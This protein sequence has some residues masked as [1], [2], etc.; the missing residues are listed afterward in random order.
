MCVKPFLI[1]LCFALLLTS[2]STELK[3]ANAFVDQSRQTQLAVYFPE[4]AQVTLVQDSDGT[5][6]KVLDSVNQNA[7]LDIMYYAFAEE[8]E[9]YGIQVYIPENQD[10]IKVDSI[11][12]LAIFSKVEISGLYTEYVDHLYDFV[13]DYDFA[14][15]LNTVNVASWVD[16][17]DGIWHPVLYHEHNLT[18]GF[19]SH[20]TGNN[21]QGMQYH[22]DIKELTKDDVYDYAVY[23]GKHYAG[24]VF[25]YMLDQYVSKALKR[26]PGRTRLHWDP[27][28]STWRDLLEDEGFVEL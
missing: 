16:I 28:T 1:G 19:E 18:D 24:Y 22:Y 4:E 10:N 6:T 3:L 17:N 2:C 26:Q 25:D 21:R 9:R 5:F 14:F 23:L 27:A 13:D 20:V 7:F 15:S 11:H 12:W 8:M